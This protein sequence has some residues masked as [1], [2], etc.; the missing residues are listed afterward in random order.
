MNVQQFLSMTTAVF[1]VLQLRAILWNSSWAAAAGVSSYHSPQCDQVH[2]LTAGTHQL[3]TTNVITIDSPNYPFTQ[4]PPRSSCRH[5]IRAPLGYTITVQCNI[6]L[7]VTG[8]ATDTTYTDSRHCQTDF[9]Y[10]STPATQEANDGYFEYFCGRGYVSRTSVFNALT[11]AYE[12]KSDSVAGYFTCTAF[13]SRKNCDCG[14][15]PRSL[16]GV[17]GGWFG[18]NG[19]IIGGQE[20]VANEYAGMAGLVDKQTGRVFCGGSISE[21]LS[22]RVDGGRCS[23]R[24]NSSVDI[25]NTC[26]MWIDRGWFFHCEIMGPF[27]FGLLN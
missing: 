19:R 26:K 16:P 17:G 1:A 14:W 27:T 21:W 9:L 20:A 6:N 11:L 12:S 25:T 15:S 13:A 24:V 10:I 23:L 8:A 5:S 4:Y 2:E 7:P 18:G 22:W 3:S